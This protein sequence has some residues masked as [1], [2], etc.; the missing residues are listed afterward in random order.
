MIIDVKVDQ[1]APNFVW[2]VLHRIE[3]MRMWL[4]IAVDNNVESKGVND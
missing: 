4:T 2:H 1:H 3:V